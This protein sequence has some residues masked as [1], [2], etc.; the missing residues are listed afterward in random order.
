MTYEESI[1]NRIIS[2]IFS[3]GRNFRKEN[4]MRLEDDF[5]EHISPV[6]LETLKFI[7]DRKKP[8]MK[9]VADYLFIA[10]PSLT[11]II[12]GLEKRKLIKRGHSE[13]DRR[14]TLLCLTEKGKDVLEKTIKHAMEK[15]HQTFSKLTKKEQETLLGLLEKIAASRK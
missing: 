12:D 9:E 3:A 6:Q 11:P 4:N 15:M 13:N 10:P 2:L 8:L 14:A 5:K 7:N 1:E